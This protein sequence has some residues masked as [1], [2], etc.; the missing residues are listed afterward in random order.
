M[1]AI[2]ATGFNCPTLSGVVRYDGLN[3]NKIATLKPNL[4]GG[5]LNGHF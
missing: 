1:K 3:F 4:Y 5:A 2:E